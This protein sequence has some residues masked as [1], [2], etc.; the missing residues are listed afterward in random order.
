MA[1]ERMR[2]LSVV[3]A[4]SADRAG[5]SASRQ[6]SSSGFVVVDRAADRGVH[7][8]AAEFFA[9]DFLPDGALHQR[10]PGEIEPRAFGH[11]QLVAEHRQIAAAGD[12]VP[13]DGGDLRMPAAE[14]TALLRKMRPKSSS[15]GK[16]S[17]CSG[18][19]MPAE[20]TR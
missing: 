3:G 9:G 20:S 8:R 7:R 13:H 12:A 5:E 16:T 6:A 18:R 2:R 1:D 17:S 4:M 15:S 10:R 14:S 19:K 11:Q